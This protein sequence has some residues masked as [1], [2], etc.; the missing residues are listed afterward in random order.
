MKKYFALFLFFQLVVYNTSAQETEDYVWYDP[1]EFVNQ[2]DGQGWSNIAY[3][4]L[5][6]EAEAVVRETAPT[7]QI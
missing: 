7:L 6:N 2:L 4:R 3:A 1:L 5:P